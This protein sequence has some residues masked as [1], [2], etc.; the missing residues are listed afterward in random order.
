[1]SS[2]ALHALSPFFLPHCSPIYIHPSLGS[3]IDQGQWQE[4]DGS[5][6]NVSSAS[7]SIYLNDRTWQRQAG[8]GVVVCR[9]A[10]TC[11]DIIFL[12]SIFS[13]QLGRSMYA[14]MHACIVQCFFS[15]LL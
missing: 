8:H 3:S 4:E 11:I 10:K 5:A 1:L 12:C 15:P 7:P 13:L 9:C 6:A 2:S 14:C